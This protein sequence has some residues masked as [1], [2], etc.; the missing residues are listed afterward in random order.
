[1]GE[2]FEC[3]LYLGPLGC[4]HAPDWFGASGAP[5]LFFAGPVRGCL[6]AA[7]PGIVSVCFGVQPGAAGP[8]GLSVLWALPVC[9]QTSAFSQPAAEDTGEPRGPSP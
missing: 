3:P 6:P 8:L 1:M 4:T 5:A 2:P 7:E 9:E